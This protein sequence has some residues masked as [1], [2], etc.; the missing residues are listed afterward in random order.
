MNT[1]IFHR[2]LS[3]IL[4]TALAVCLMGSVGVVLG[5]ERTLAVPEQPIAI[6]VGQS[7]AIVVKVTPPLQA[8]ETLAYESGN[9]GFVTVD[10]KGVL[11]GVHEGTTVVSITAPDGQRTDVRVVVSAAGT[12][13]GTA[14]VAQNSAALEGILAGN[15]DGELL[16]GDI[17]R[18]IAHVLPYNVIG[19]N[20]FTISSSNPAVLEAVDAAK[21]VKALKEGTATVTVKT[22]DGKF[23]DSINF[24]VV[25]R[26]D[27][28]NSGKT[29]TIEP[30]K[31]GIRYDD[32][33]EEAAKANS[34]GLYAALRYTADNGFARLLMEK[35][36]MLYIEPSDTIHMVSNVQW[37]LN[38][39]EIRLRP[40]NYERYTAI[41]FAEKDHVRVLENASIVNGTLTG[42][43]DEKEKYLPN[44]KKIPKTEGACTIV[45]SEGAN[46]GIRNLT[47]R[48]SIGFNMSS[49]LGSNSAGVVRFAK[50]PISTRNME[51]G[52]FDE[53]GKPIAA[54]G[55]IRTIKPLDISKLK[56]PY[57]NIGLPLGYMGYPMANSR[58]YDVYFYDKEMKL[59]S[60]DR[61]LL[62]Y[63]QY[64]LPK[65]AVYMQ[66][67]L[68]QDA[69]PARGVA[70]FGDAVA[71]VEN[72]AIPVRNYMIGCTIEDN[73]SCGFAA[74]GGQ[75]W[76]IKDNTFRRNGGRM[77][78]CDIDWEDGWE[79]MQGDLIEGNRFESRIN[80]ITCAGIGLVFAN[81]T[82]SGESIF[83]G[84]TQEYSLLDNVFEK[85]QAEG[86]HR[87]KVTMSS[88]ADVYVVGGQFKDAWVEYDRH[89]KKA[90]FIGS[91][92]A[93][94]TNV[95]FDTT[96]VLPGEAGHLVNCTIINAPK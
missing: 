20:P 47:V 52:G 54:K 85:S 87:V 18:I 55:L 3:V 94:F 25:A 67:T 65:N 76:L 42:E 39:S 81:N 82:F 12:A 17:E 15:A 27:T 53:Q 32:A 72:R 37:D 28:G 70:D 7:K 46:N 61:G 66:V 96:K 10:G 29:Y 57:Y 36:K 59:I 6:G 41:E 4:L 63:R 19:G 49:R 86:A 30:K 14:P 88:Q 16:V 83:Y 69:V 23:S 79:Y 40:N 31:F 33:S 22:L 95:K 75:E 84:R 68:Y 58:I 51:P 71:F 8:G 35:G 91:Y 2:H 43:R 21:V 24:K 44:W 62:R 45:F 60:G 34:A 5:G 48:K 11:K 1:L 38:G 56:T 26:P 93:T 73:Y 92:E 89:H 77:P 50:Y 74:C 90:P 78:G 80:V 64:A 9:P 13:E